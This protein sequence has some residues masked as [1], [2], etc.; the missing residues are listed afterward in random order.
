MPKFIN[1]FNI[2]TGDKI[3]HQ[4]NSTVPKS[5]PLSVGTTVQEIVPPDK[6]VLAFL[7]GGADIRIGED[8]SLANGYEVVAANKWSLPIPVVAGHNIYI[9]IDAASG[10]TTVN[11]RFEVLQ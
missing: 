1:S 2:T 6:A 8:S 4:D 9:R 10:T 7:S 3:S 5:S 11:F